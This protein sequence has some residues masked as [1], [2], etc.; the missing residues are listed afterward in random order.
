VF[1]AALFLALTGLLLVADLRQPRR[2]LWVLTRPQWRS[3]L[4]KGAYVIAAYSAMLLVC[5][6]GS[7]GWLPF[8]LP[9]W[10]T[11]ATVLLAAATALYTAFLFGQAKGRDLWQS[12]LLAPHLLVQALAAGAA[13][14]Q[15]E[16]LRWLLPIN[17]LL[18]AGEVYG[19]HATEDARRA[20]RLIQ[21]DPR[22]TTGVLATGHLLPL[23]LLWTSSGTGVLAGALTLAG[24]WSWEHLY[25]QAPQKVA[26]A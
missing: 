9:T 24:L 11:V 6:A 7:V 20:A 1:V 10:T 14:F 17:G 15:P 16:W 23:A 3:W 2:F 19:R 5:F 25:V 8:E 4:V 18:V 21:D 26:L 22:F 13:L 12:A